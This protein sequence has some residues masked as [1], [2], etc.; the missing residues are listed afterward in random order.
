MRLRR[1]LDSP[2][3][4]EPPVFEHFLQSNRLTEASLSYRLGLTPPIG[5]GGSEAQA[6]S[7]ALAE[8]VEPP[9]STEHEPGVG[10]YLNAVQPLID[11]AL[12]RLRGEIDVLNRGAGY[13]L[14]DSS[15]LEPLVDALGEQ[16]LLVIIKPLTLE[17]HIA[18]MAGTLGGDTSAERFKYFT[19]GLCR[20]QMRERVFSQYPVMLKR[21]VRI[22]DQWVDSIQEFLRRTV[23]DLPVLNRKF[24]VDSKLI[25]AQLS[26]GDAHHQG[27]RVVIATFGGGRRLVY[28]PRPMTAAVRFQELVGW[29]NERGLDP[30]LRTFRVLDVGAYGWSEFVETS[31]CQSADDVATFYRRVGALLAVL[32][33]VR[34]TDAHFDNLIA[35]GSHPV[36]IDL[37]TVFQ[38]HL[39]DDSGGFGNEHCLAAAAKSVLTVGLLP[40]P[41]RVANQLVDISG[42]GA[43]PE[44][45]TPLLTMGFDASGTDAMRVTKVQFAL[46]ASSHL[47]MLDG[48]FHMATSH[49]EPLVA[50]F[51]S[52]Y[53][54]MMANASEMSDPTGPIAAFGDCEVRIL[55]RPTATYASLLQESNHPMALTDGTEADRVLGQIWSGVASSSILQKTVL[56]EF[57]QLQQGDIPFFS[58]RADGTTVLSG[59]DRELES[60]LST[61]G[62]DAVRSRLA[63]MSEADL[64]LQEWIIRASM[65]CL[66]EMG[67]APFAPESPLRRD[68]SAAGLAKDALLATCV[69][70]G[71]RASWLTLAPTV[72]GRSDASLDHY[73]A[74]VGIDL[75]D[76]LAGIALFLIAYAK[77]TND[78]QALQVGDQVL[79]ELDRRVQVSSSFQPVGAFTGLSGIVYVY[80]HIAHLVPEK[81]AELRAKSDT[82]LS[83]IEAKLRVDPAC[84]LMSGRAGVMLCLLAAYNVWSIR[85]Y[86]DLA[87]EC[88][89]D[90]VGWLGQPPYRETPRLRIANQRGMS[91]GYAGI[92][93]ALA[94]IGATAGEKPLTQA[95]LELTR[96]ESSLIASGDWTDPGDE[97]H[98]KQ[99]TW[100]HGAPG[101]ALAR[102]VTLGH[103]LDPWVEQE[104]RSA[105]AKC[106]EAPVLDSESLCH[107]S[108]GNLD[109]L[110]HAAAT[111]PGELLWSDEVRRRVSELRLTLEHRGLRCARPNYVNVPGLMTGLSGI[112]YGVLRL[113]SPEVF[114]SV[115]ALASPPMSAAAAFLEEPGAT[116]VFS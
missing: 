63:R 102:L 2:A 20:R 88:G 30:E 53:R 86:L 84:D 21:S 104:A 115:L 33:V 98:A 85:N 43:R 114:P 64:S 65:A 105:L 101:I 97:H 107:G 10:A 32:H 4:S 80:A 15:V 61:S 57:N 19:E 34:G 78:K 95:A 39:E 25:S 52:A 31:D 54:M 50:G 38:P 62:V 74:E 89:K 58:C 66:G 48:K 1:W 109:T 87:V 17:L 77:Q 116:Y 27:R 26:V 11:N 36:L 59:D 68:S 24:G 6:W 12:R 108:L 94:T 100:C 45:P 93:M 91:H 49:V 56:H 3:F 40:T 44:H 110:I 9:P 8:T 72:T 23:R 111:F 75:Y 67:D 106:L 81:S 113:A 51:S 112:G 37:E 92:A 29:L 18:R 69:T 83:L 99:A 41:I 70:S 47:P 90:L 5:P 79:N 35:C 42:L 46:D 55:L 7:V 16:L 14:V 13:S 76:G 96:L 73:I 22:C 103:T 82:L 60:V 28:K 71:S